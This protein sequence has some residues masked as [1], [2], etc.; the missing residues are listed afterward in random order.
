MFVWLCVGLLI[1][2][3]GSVPSVRLV[4]GLV[5]VLVLA[6]VPFD[7][8]SPSV[9]VGFGGDSLKLTVGG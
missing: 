9:G 2:F 5:V 1:E 7:Y 6:V 4:R 8:V 3:H